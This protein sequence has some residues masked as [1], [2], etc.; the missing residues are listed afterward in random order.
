MGGLDNMLWGVLIFFSFIVILLLFSLTFYVKIDEDISISVGIIGLKFN[1]N[2]DEDEKTKKV[3]IKKAKKAKPIKSEKKQI[4][5]PKKE[6]NEKKSLSENIELWTRIIKSLMPNFLRMLKKTRIKNLNIIIKVASEYPDETALLYGQ[7]SMGI[8][9]IIAHLTNCI[10]V[11]IKKIEITPDF[12]KQET[13]YYIYFKVK[14]RLCHI[15]F[16]L[17]GMLIK[18]VGNTIFKEKTSSIL[19]N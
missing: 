18:F 9:N 13:D 2:L 6:A 7:F 10:K 5:N 3:K 14:I 4:S 15:L 17:F 16:A 12:T 1:I 8:Y 19:Q 11:N